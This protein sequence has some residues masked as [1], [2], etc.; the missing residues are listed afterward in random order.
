MEL[1]DIY[2]ENDKYL[3][4]EYLQNG[5]D[6]FYL[7]DLGNG[8]AF[9]VVPYKYVKTSKSSEEAIDRFKTDL[10]SFQD[11][12]SK[13]YLAVGETVKMFKLDDEYYVIP[14]KLEG[15][16]SPYE[17]KASVIAKANKKYND[18]INM[19]R[20]L[21]SFLEEDVEV[22]FYDKDLSVAYTKLLV[23]R[24]KEQ[25]DE[26][27]KWKAIID[28]V[29]DL[30]EL[31]ADKIADIVDRVIETVK[32]N[33]P[34]KKEF[35]SKMVEVLGKSKN[36]CEQVRERLSDIA[37][38]EFDKVVEFKDNCVNALRRKGTAL[39]LTGALGAVVAGGVVF[40][41]RENVDDNGFVTEKTN[42]VNVLDKYMLGHVNENGDYVDFMG[43][44]HKDTYGNIARIN[45]LRP[46]IS[47]ML[48]AVE[49][50]AEEAY[51]D[52]VGVA[53]IGSG[54]TT[55]IDNEGNETK[56]KMGD[57]MSKEEAMVNKWKYVEKYLLSFCGDKVGRTISD[58]EIFCTIGGGFCWGPTKLSSSSMYKAIL[59]NEGEDSVV[60]KSS[61]FRV[62]KG[63]LKRAYFFANCDQAFKENCS[64][65]LDLPVYLSSSMEYIHSAI[66]DWELH[67]FLPCEQYANG[68]YKKVGRNDVP[69]TL[70]NNKE[71]CMPY[72]NDKFGDLLKDLVAKGERSLIPSAK[73]KD[74]MPKDMVSHLENKYDVSSEFKS[75][76]DYYS[77]EYCNN[78]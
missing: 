2:S 1:E 49:G 53:T 32:D 29:S 46:E 8:E 74:L 48:I 65:L 11:E 57:E 69:M 16:I 55:H 35:L 21:N 51:R 78:R 62:Q 15:K 25:T 37:G 24:A 6:D 14:K 36:K 70:P 42:G 52:G 4:E 30:A 73:L 22:S 31:G 44:V 38:K 13:K 23:M 40:G 17:L 76:I 72:Y 19:Y 58:K 39:V 67:D 77:T 71:F 61:G 50:L 26:E 64:D 3:I 7:A 66:Y 41:D 33:A 45:E 5:T 56:V 75:S 18:V 43:R 27:N 68:K 47:A 12:E 34:R 63:L 10:L 60:M 54:S 20:D 28:K 9:F 59:D